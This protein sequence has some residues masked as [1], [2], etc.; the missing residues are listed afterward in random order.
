[1][2]EPF[3]M[4]SATGTICARA[5]GCHLPVFC[6]YGRTIA[7]TKRVAELEALRAVLVAIAV[8]S[9]SDASYVDL[10]WLV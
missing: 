9:F 8:N 6:A 2:D 4:V 10:S 5:V 7:A 3:Q 1:M